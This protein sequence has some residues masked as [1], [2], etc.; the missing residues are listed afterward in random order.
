MSKIAAIV[1]R[2]NV[3]KST[4]FNRLIG[5]RKA[6]VDDM[7]GVTRDRHYGKAEWLNR[8]F[9]VIDTGGYVPHSSDVFESAIRDQ[10]GIA[11]EESDLLI[12]M[13]DVMTGITDLDQAFAE[14]LRK[15]KKPVILAV[16][17]VDNNDRLIDATEFYSLGF[18]PLF[19]VSSI[20]GSGTG[21]LLDQIYS[22]LDL[23]SE[24][25]VIPTEELEEAD[26]EAVFP[27]GL[28]LPKVAIV[29]RPNVGKSSLV[30]AFLGYDRNIVTP[31][32]GTTRDTIHTH[33]KAFGKEML[34]VDTAGIRKKGK[35]HENIEFY[36]VLRAI[37]AIEE[38]DVCVI[39]V[40]ATLGVQA[41]DLNLFHLAMKNNKGIVLLINKWDLV[42]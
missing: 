6:I 21:E 42:E 3:G 15:S 18:D 37:R 7:S 32:A 29:G 5:A 13:V 36:S 28:D 41:Q 9:V 31:I 10:V 16:N 38:C 14:L 34:L 27:K 23:E 39:M 25:E 12:F 35:V 17:K 1:G 26:D 11:I 40:D 19:N 2:P 30:N 8:E 24:P 33:Y 4:L 20:T 22:M